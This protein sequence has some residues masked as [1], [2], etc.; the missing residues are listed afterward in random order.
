M[1]QTLIISIAPFISFLLLM[2]GIATKQRYLFASAC[3]S[4]PRCSA[5]KVGTFERS[6]GSFI[7][8]S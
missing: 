6:R 5:G 1:Y 7:C 2:K 3:W 8:C 4:V